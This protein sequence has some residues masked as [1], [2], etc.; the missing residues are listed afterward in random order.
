MPMTEHSQP[1]QG[2]SE[3]D[4]DWKYVILVFG[5]GEGPSIDTMLAAE[6][7]ACVILEGDR[8]RARMAEWHQQGSR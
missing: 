4:Y 2:D 1:E 8:T 7:A 6:K 5:K 3:P